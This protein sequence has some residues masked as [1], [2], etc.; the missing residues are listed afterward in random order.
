MET[1]AFEPEGAVEFDL[2]HGIVRGAGDRLMVVPATLFE[3]I[4]VSAGASAAVTIARAIGAACGQRAALRLGGVEAARGAS[5]E[6]V[7]SHLA[8]ELALT[9][10]GAAHL[11]RWGRALVLVLANTPV[12]D[13]VAIAALL[14]G[15]LAAVVDR[16]VATITLARDASGVR[17]LVA[18]AAAVL[19]TKELLERG[20]AW[21]E[22]LTRIQARGDA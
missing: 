18:S 11:E 7:L 4:A 13:D 9:G 16:P 6:S 8:G 20:M 15:A 1:G 5:I 2:P 17:V 19:R 12:R 10:V 3:E 14:E 22:A 21:G